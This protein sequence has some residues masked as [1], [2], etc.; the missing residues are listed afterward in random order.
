MAEV[1]RRHE[2]VLRLYGDAS[3]A[4]KRRLLERYGVRYAYYGSQERAMQAEAGQVV[5]DSFRD[6]LRP[7][8]DGTGWTLY[9]VD[10]A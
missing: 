4:E 2:D 3:D 1:A 9:A 5:E 8:L 6:M 7:V 10:P